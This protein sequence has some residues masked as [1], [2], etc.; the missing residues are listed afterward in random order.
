MPPQLKLD[1]LILATKEA[2]NQIAGIEGAPDTEIEK[3]KGEVLER[4]G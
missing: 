2:R 1:E 3:A 4:A